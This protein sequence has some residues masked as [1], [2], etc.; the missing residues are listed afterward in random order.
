[1]I[2]L[3]SSLTVTEVDVWVI[4]DHH[5]S[6]H[7]L[8]VMAC[9]RTLCRGHLLAAA[10]SRVQVPHEVCHSSFAI[11]AGVL[12]R[13]RANAEDLQSRGALDCFLDADNLTDLS[14][15]FQV[16]SSDTE[17]FVFLG[18]PSVGILRAL[19]L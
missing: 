18:S 11:T 8:P 17:T 14:Q 2:L 10:T 9:R 19:R 1:M 4:I 5:V 15:L 6:F 12:F 13:L 3:L 16:V 7:N